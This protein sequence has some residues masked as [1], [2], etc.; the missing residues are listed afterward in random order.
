MDG[1]KAIWWKDEREIAELIWCAAY[2][3]R[4]IAPRSVRPERQ[5][6]PT[7]STDGGNNESA[8]SGEG[9]PS[10][11][12]SDTSIPFAY[13]EKF[14]RPTKTSPNRDLRESAR[15]S[16]VRVPDPFP[17]PEPAAITK[18][19]LPLAR[20][21]PGARADELDIEATI[22]RT[23]EA[24]GLPILVFRPP[25]ERWFEV[26]LLIDRSPPMEFWGD[27]AGGMATLF[28]WQGFFRDVRVWWF[29]TG[30]NEARLL[31]G[32]GQI[33]RNARGLVASPG[34]R[35][36]I[37]LTDTL[38]KAWR[39]G[40]AFA[41][42][43]VLGKEHPVTIAHVFPRELWQRTALEGAILRPLIAPGP[44][45][46][47]ALLQVGEKLR[48]KQNLYRFPIFNLSPAHFT[49]WA[50]FI[51]GSGGNSIQGVLIRSTTAEVDGGETVEDTIDGETE[52]PEELLKGFLLDAS[53]VAREL[54]KVLA[55]VP[56][57]PPV[58]R[59]AQ[60]RFLPDSRHWHLAEVFFSGL[61]Q[62]STFSPEGATVPDAWYEFLPGIRDL[63][64]A[65]SAARRTI[66][67]W[68]GI[69]DYIRER[70]GDLRGFQ[71][72]IP[73]P[74]GSLQDTV[75]DRDLYFAEVDVAVLRTWGG[76]Y[77]NL[78]RELEA[79]VTGR[80]RQIDLKINF[81]HLE[82]LLTDRRWQEADRATAEI[83]IKASDREQEGWLEAED[84]QRLPGDI[85]QIVDRLWLESSNQHFGFSVQKQ[86]WSS[87]GGN[88]E[89]EDEEVYKRFAERVGWYIRERDHW[90]TWDEH[91]FSL[92]AP[93]GHLPRYLPSQSKRIRPYLLS[94][95]DLFLLF[96]PDLSPFPFP[97]LQEF[98]FTTTLLTLEETEPLQRI[99]FETATVEIQRQ[100]RRKPKIVINKSSG[101][102]WGYRESL[103]EALALEMMQIPG[104]T[105]LM[106]SPGDEPERYED[107]SPQH[108]VTV[109]AFFMGKYPVTQAQWRVVAGLPQIDHPLDPD[110][111]EFKGDDR[112][113]EQV[114]WLEAKEFCGRLEKQTN[115]PYRLPTE[116]EW[117][118]ACRAG[119]TTPF[120]FGETITPDLAN[121]DW[122]QSY[123]KITV[124]KKKDFRGTTLVGSFPANGFGL[125]D[126]HGNVW[127]WCEDHWH[128]NYEGAPTD[129]S[130]W[131]D[132]EQKEPNYVR[133]G[134]SWL[135]GPWSC[136]SATRSTY[137]A[138]IRIGNLG[139]R[140]VCVAS[141]TL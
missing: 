47:N 104:G 107:E 16:P 131:F 86:I 139:F 7:P 88:L 74:Q 140:V 95:P 55:A 25:L 80:K 101:E 22:E 126:M 90:L 33:E 26:H 84:L 75:S 100:G 111:S 117:E 6:E 138:G 52:S 1:E 10:P 11:K 64:L 94:R 28:R 113:V 112:P 32:A 45:S 103:S 67:I 31:S 63:L 130:K 9:I 141:R 46:P 44:A 5:P 121:Y 29:E 105:F 108:E 71:A 72:L 30:E 128:E 78:A 127:E 17:I 81:T 82:K 37:V 66:D 116:A 59:L 79:T 21:V 133:R 27:L 24:G 56:L 134:G 38:G 8:D 122:E 119:T 61:V 77:A 49:T 110:P 48:T 50:K 62:K 106:G 109:E 12:E 23:A 57:I 89:R 135:H 137:A 115:R 34:N 85:L 13:P 91:T 39:S 65:D 118:Y 15:S 70:Y 68:R 4:I 132:L 87:L 123:N 76:E 20:R 98:E 124:T 114:S 125:Y 19:L 96:D 93:R 3:D 60:R 99:P 120:Y 43:A 69:G 58:M 40:S 41:T 54:A 14:D 102:G 97:P 18:A 42:L 2:L 136:R 53:P 51:A 92:D 129:G 73:N 36:F 83:L 35:L